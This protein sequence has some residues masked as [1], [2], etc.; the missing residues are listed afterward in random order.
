MQIAKYYF[1]Y[2]IN[3]VNIF[4]TF[5]IRYRIYSVITSL[6]PLFEHIFSHYA[7]FAVSYFYDDKS[8]ITTGQKCNIFGLLRT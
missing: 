2:F 8:P 1:I 3:F 6:Q 4:S 7:L 5:T